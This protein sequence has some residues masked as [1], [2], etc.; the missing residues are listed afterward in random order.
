MLDE[1]R[2]RETYKNGTNEDTPWLGLLNMVLALG[3]I[4]AQTCLETTH[5]IYYERAR[6]ILTF[7]SFGSGR[8][9]IVQALALMGGLYLHYVN[10]P[11]Y[12]VAITGAALRMA[13]ALG[14]HRRQPPERDAGNNS[15]HN[16][17]HDE[18][19]TKRRTWWSLVCLDTWGTM[20]LGR[21]ST[22]SC[23]GPAISTPRPS[24]EDFTAYPVT[25]R[26]MQLTASVSFCEIFARLQDRLSTTPCLSMS[27]MVHFDAQLERV[28]GALP[29]TMRSPNQ[30]PR[31]MLVPRAI[32]K[33][34]YQNARLILHRP[35]L[36]A[37]ALSGRSVLD[38]AESEQTSINICRNVASDSIVDIACDWQP[39]HICGW[40]A[41]W[42]L[43]QASM[44]PLVSLFYER[45]N[46][47][48]CGKWR[49]QVEMALRLLQSM[50]LWSPVAKRSREVIVGVYE[51][52]ARVD[53]GETMDGGG[54]GLAAHDNHQMWAH[55]QQQ[56]QNMQHLQS[57]FDHDDMWPSIWSMGEWPVFPFEP[58]DFGPAVGDTV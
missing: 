13:Y 43:F 58:M 11:N 38:L 33:W 6:S 41:V 56:E 32:L 5:V 53:G 55:P 29:P 22:D 51:S 27:E 44:V 47:A 2:F 8:I 14:I 31:S 37:A 1:Y 54:S 36:L 48:E 23:F 46:A 3:S 21:P 25:D 50:E 16:S 19:E 30:C 42:F 24:Y 34:R 20:T 28:F 9:E 52:L 49:N 12:A 10:M 57:P 45:G 15:S 40:N 18:R 26:A 7:D 4:A 17:P 39:D 35:T